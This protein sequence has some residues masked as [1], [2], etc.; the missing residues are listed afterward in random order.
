MNIFPVVCSIAMAVSVSIAKAEPYRFEIELGYFQGDSSAR[1]LAFDNKTL[2]GNISIFLDNIDPNDGPL[3]ELSFLQKASGVSIGYASND[4]TNAVYTFADFPPDNLGDFGDLDVTSIG[5]LFVTSQD[6]ILLA[7]YDR[8][9]QSIVAPG[10]EMLETGTDNTQS[11]GLGKY[12]DD[13]TTVI[14]GY[15]AV[16]KA[17][18]DT[19]GLTWHQ[20]R[21]SAEGAYRWGYDMELSYI[22]SSDDS[23]YGV[24]LGATYYVSPYLGVSGGIDFEKTDVTDATMFIISA[25]YFINQRI[26]FGLNYCR[27][28]TDLDDG[29]A[30]RD[31]IEVELYGASVAVR[32]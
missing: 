23:G 13:S 11:L 20:L 14:L 16:D 3:A 19:V 1:Q 21:K 4:F 25:D 2:G 30:A 17:D 6:F 9:D 7:E 8:E 27:S 22:D 12:L 18:V 15:S 32:F 10:F 28:D 5:L 26:A 24:A 31:S 29:F